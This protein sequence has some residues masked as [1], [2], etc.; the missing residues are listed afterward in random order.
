M[1]RKTILVIL[2]FTMFATGLSTTRT[3]HADYQY[4]VNVHVEN[5][6]TGS[7]QSNSICT[8]T[9]NP[10]GN[11]VTNTTDSSGV[12]QAVYFTTHDTA[13]DVGCIGTDG[14]VGTVTDSTLS[15]QQEDTMQMALS[16]LITPS[17]VQNL[18]ASIV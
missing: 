12:T 3:V 6:L 18:Q 2:L 16:K 1:I 14:N 15:A 5:S 9:F 7:P 8:F 17:P 11:I 10:S 13:V 4:Q